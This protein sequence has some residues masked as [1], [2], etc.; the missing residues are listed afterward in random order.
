M[1]LILMTQW[2][3]LGQE[4]KTTQASGAVRS[5]RKKRK[6]SSQN[7]D[8]SQKTKAKTQETPRVNI[9]SGTGILG[10]LNEILN[11]QKEII[12]TMKVMKTDLKNLKTKV[13][14]KKDEEPENVR[15]PNR[16]RNAVKDFFS[17]GE[18]R[19]LKWDFQKR[20][21]DESNFEMTDFIKKSVKGIA[22]EVSS[23]VLD[24]AV[25]RYFTSKK[26]GATRK[27]RNKDV[28]HKQ[29]QATYERKKEKL[30]R[31]QMAL[32]KKTN[33]NKDKRA[34][35][36][37]LLESKGAKK[38]MSSDEEGNDGFISHPYSW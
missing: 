22:P 17:S 9:N 11:N 10:K 33:W 32:E 6:D 20:Y 25:K 3:L 28:A 38:L 5:P 4:Q 36:K 19:E 2:A 8:K 29:R 26:E 37:S 14:K 18:D 7:V 35:V 12:S 13:E 30:R 1:R 16:I 23:E 31:R 24:A 34:K 27:A 21:N 15:V